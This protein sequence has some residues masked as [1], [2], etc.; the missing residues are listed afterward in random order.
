MAFAKKGWYVCA[1][2]N[3]EQE[4]G[5]GLAFVPGRREGREQ[6]LIELT[7]E[8][9]TALIMRG[10][11]PSTSTARGALDVVGITVGFTST[12]GTFFNSPGSEVKKA[13]TLTSALACIYSS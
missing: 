4:V 13:G 11:R 1:A 8:L 9:P 6:R 3:A 5:S 7:G 2:E 10:H 12:L